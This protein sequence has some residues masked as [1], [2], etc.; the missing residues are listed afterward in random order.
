MARMVMM[1]VAAFAL[2]GLALFGAPRLPGFAGSGTPADF[3]TGG[4]PGATHLA[5]S[6]T[7]V[8]PDPG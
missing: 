6:S 5:C 2:G 1:L 8:D 3:D 7:C 4:S